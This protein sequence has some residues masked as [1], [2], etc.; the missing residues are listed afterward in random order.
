MGNGNIPYTCGVIQVKDL[1]F[2]VVPH[3]S[4]LVTR[5]TCLPSS[6]NLQSKFLPKAPACGKRQYS[7]IT[8]RDEKS[9]PFF[10]VPH[11]SELV[12]LQTC[13]PSSVN[14]Q[15]KFLPPMTRHKFCLQGIYAEV[16]HETTVLQNAK[17]KRQF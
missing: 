16:I 5:Q 14:L 1:S 15:S 3:P 7:L 12:T 2:F 10:V 11:P 9:S 13:L 6:V 4:E 8:R 17:P